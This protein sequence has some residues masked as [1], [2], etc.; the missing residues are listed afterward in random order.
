MT[1][2]QGLN[3]PLTPREEEVLSLLRLGLTDAEIADRLG[4]S[5]AGVSY[6]VSQIIS[7]FGV[8]N[9]YEAAEWPKLPPW[10]LTAFAPI[11]PML[12]PLRWL[13]KPGVQL[14]SPLATAAVVGPL[15]GGIA[16]MVILLTRAGDLQ[17]PTPLLASHSEQRLSTTENTTRIEPPSESD[18]RSEPGGIN[19]TSNRTPKSSAVPRQ[20]A[21]PPRAVSAAA[22]TVATGE[23][24]TCFV[25]DGLVRCTGQGFGTVQTLVP[26]ISE[27]MEAVT[28]GFSHM[29]ALSESGGVKCWGGSYGTSA[30]SIPGFEDGIAAVSA[31]GY[32]TCALTTAG[33]VGC[34]GD[35]TY[36]QL[37]DGSLRSG[38]VEVAAGYG[39]TC[40]VLTTGTATCWGRNGSGELG[41]GTTANSTS[42]VDVQGVTQVIEIAPGANQTCAL[43]ISGEV[44]CWGHSFGLFPANVPGLPDSV[45]SISAKYLHSCVVMDSGGV[46]CWGDNTF[47]QLGDGMQCGSACMRAVD[48]LGLSSGVAAVSAGV[49][50]SCAVMTSGAA[51]CWG[52]NTVGQL[53]DGT[54]EAQLQPVAV[55]DTDTPPT[56]TSA[57]CPAQTCGTP[58]SEAPTPVPIVPPRT[59]PGSVADGLG[60]SLSVDVDFDGISDCSTDGG[61]TTCDAALGSVFTL[62]LSLDSLGPDV[63][64]Y[65]GF[66]ARI[67]YDGVAM[68]TN[69]IIVA[70]WCTDPVSTTLIDWSAFG[71]GLFAAAHSTSYTGPIAMV[72][73][74]CAVSG[75]IELRHGEGETA[76]LVGMNSYYYEGDPASESLTINCT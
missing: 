55:L 18:L 61:T 23:S 15:L 22:T 7:K 70:P 6:H 10:W 73:F 2:T 54:T 31:G 24:N 68:Q 47:G 56:P 66:D 9:R 38:V 44:K 74:N 48:V 52:I 1:R 11:G 19:A 37:G 42:P 53:G 25:H 67:F 58:P 71:C 65:A 39:H 51:R 28:S 72:A 43:T 50:H 32:H 46:K 3:E 26:G 8:A 12:R 75:H 5:R 17:R 63:S 64:Q 59:L 21:V 27:R 34:W 20:T 40:A 33:A 76:L 62:T 16:L 36:G 29:C 30:V 45:A 49:Y 69:P 14:A 4:I 13:Q 57:I 41:D 35:N 60:W